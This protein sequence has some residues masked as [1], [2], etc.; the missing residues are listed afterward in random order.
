MA[1]ELNR[2]RDNSSHLQAAELKGLLET[3][4]GDVKACRRIVLTRYTFGSTSTPPPQHIRGP[5]TLGSPDAA[6]SQLRSVQKEIRPHTNPVV[7]S[8]QHQSCWHFVEGRPALFSALEEETIM[9]L[10]ATAAI[11]IAEKLNK[12]KRNKRKWMKGWLTKRN[13]L[14][15]DTLLQMEV[16]RRRLGPVV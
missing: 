10:E 3:G 9:A 8:R 4:A 1:V 12:P 14:S 15:H 5:Y 11:Y 2:S 13:E 7:S 6:L 16:E